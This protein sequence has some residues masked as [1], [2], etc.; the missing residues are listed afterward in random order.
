MSFLD[1]LCAIYSL[2]KQESR[3]DRL[4]STWTL[5]S[6]A[7]QLLLTCA[8]PELKTIVPVTHTCEHTCGLVQGQ[9]FDL[10]AASLMMCLITDYADTANMHTDISH[11]HLFPSSTFNQLKSFSKT[12]EVILM[13]R[14]P[15]VCRHKLHLQCWLKF[16]IS[17]FLN[18]SIFLNGPEQWLYYT[19]QWQ[20]LM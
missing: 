1:W 16:T 8:T 4:W 17:F 3:S 9:S 5:C 19:T 15:N 12:P 11:L 6:C 13:D 10:L 18:E 14:C 2:L 7:P 20:S